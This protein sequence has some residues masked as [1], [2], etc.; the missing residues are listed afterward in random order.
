VHQAIGSISTTQ[1]VRGGILATLI[2]G[3]QNL[4]VLTNEPLVL[5]PGQVV[6]EFQ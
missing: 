4:N 6:A 3:N 1:P 2:I 5:F